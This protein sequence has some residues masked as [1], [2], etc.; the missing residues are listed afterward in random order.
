MYCA[1]LVLS[2]LMAVNFAHEYRSVF[3]YT[4]DTCECSEG[5]KVDLFCTVSSLSLAMPQNAEVTQART[6][7]SRGLSGSSCMQ[8]TSM[9]A[10]MYSGRSGQLMRSCLAMRSAALKS[11]WTS[12]SE[13]SHGSEWIQCHAWT[14]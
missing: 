3:L 11:G 12:L 5:L 8:I 14:L 10:T 13:M 2:I 6:T 4:D 9:S 7:A 1:T